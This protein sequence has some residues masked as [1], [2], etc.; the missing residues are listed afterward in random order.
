MTIQSDLWEYFTYEKFSNLFIGIAKCFSRESLE[1]F[2]K[3]LMHMHKGTG[4]TSYLYNS[5]QHGAYKVQAIELQGN[6][7]I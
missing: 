5:T 1:N 7:G 3:L 6:D 2:V 4:R